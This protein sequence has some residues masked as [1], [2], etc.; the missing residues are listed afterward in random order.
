KRIEVEFTTNKAQDQLLKMKAEGEVQINYNTFFL[1]DYLEIKFTKE[2]IAVPDI[3][4]G[5]RP[6][7]YAKNNAHS[8]EDIKGSFNVKKTTDG[9]IAFGCLH[10]FASER[11]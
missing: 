5:T 3:G 7:C 4:I 2:L 1:K 6:V 9:C 11:D 10:V 8:N